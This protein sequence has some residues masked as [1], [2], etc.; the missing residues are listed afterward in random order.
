MRSTVDINDLLDLQL[1][2]RAKKLGL[3]YKEILN[4]TLAAGLNHLEES[5]LAPFKVV[6]KECGF[7]P[8]IDTGHLNRLA[9]ELDD[10]ERFQR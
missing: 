2:R 3:S 10:D 1:R 5:R 8:G 4:R 6:A 7:K 9:D